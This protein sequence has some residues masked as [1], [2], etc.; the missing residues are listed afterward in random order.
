MKKVFV[1]DLMDNQAKMAFLECLDLPEYPEN[2]QIFYISK[3]LDAESVL[4]DQK[5]NLDIRESMV[6]RLVEIFIFSSTI[7]KKHKENPYL[8]L[9]KG[10]PGWP[11]EP[12]VRGMN[13]ERGSI[14]L[15]GAPGEPGSPGLPG[16]AGLPGSIGI[17]GIKGVMGEVGEPG[18]PGIP[19]EEGLSGPTGQPGSPGSI[20]AMGYEGAYGD[21][22][23]PGKCL[24]LP[25]VVYFSK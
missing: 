9:F 18:A 1:Q 20:G 24:Y 4:M 5:E 16:F 2:F 25:G 10:I 12:G 6:L 11:G 15:D 21:R 13:G 7:I 3:F 23:E 8:F 14:G 19:G 17:T 22:G